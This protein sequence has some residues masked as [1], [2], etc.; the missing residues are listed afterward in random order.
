MV[1]TMDEKLVIL[2]ND[3]DYNNSDAAALKRVQLCNQAGFFSRSQ[4]MD[5]CSDDCL[6]MEIFDRLMLIQA[7]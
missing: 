3:I 1:Q 5:L 2:A 6:D 7:F 4:E